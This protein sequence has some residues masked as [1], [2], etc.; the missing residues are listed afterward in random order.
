MQLSPHAIIIE[1]QDFYLINKPSGIGMHTENQHNQLGIIVQLQQLLS[2]SSPLF[3]VHRLDKDTSGLLLVARN[4]SAAAALGELFSQRQ[5]EKYYLALAGNKP[6][7]KQGLIQGD[8][9]KSRNGN[10]KLLRS[11]ENP[12]RSY[13]LSYSCGTDI[14]KARLYLLK[15]ETGRTHQLRVAMKSIG[16]PIW[17]DTRYGGEPAAR[18]MLHA[19]ALR[20]MWQGTLH[21][22]CYWPSDSDWQALQPHHY[23]E[24]AEPWC[25]RWPQSP[26]HNA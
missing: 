5:I 7:K 16:V 18:L 23:P 22:Y 2:T 1:H 8:M 6:K 13:F 21:S 25:C 3:P 20:F 15:P 17:G 14:A 11:N 12:A 26:Q 24:L 9:A 10:Y 19:Y 4:K